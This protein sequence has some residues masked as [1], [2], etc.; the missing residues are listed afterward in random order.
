MAES[1]DSGTNKLDNIGASS[2]VPI[3]VPNSETIN[4]LCDHEGCRQLFRDKTLLQQHLIVH[5]KSKSAD[6][7]TNESDNLGVSSETPR[8]INS[9]INTFI[10]DYKG[11]L[12]LFKNKTL[13]KL[14]Q[15]D[16][17]ELTS[18]KCRYPGCPLIFS[19]MSHLQF[20]EKSHFGKQVKELKCN[21]CDKTFDKKSLLESHKLT[22]SSNHKFKC[23]LNG[24]MK[25]YS[26]EVELMHHWKVHADQRGSMELSDELETTETEKPFFCDEC[27]KSF[28][29]KFELE[30]HIHPASLNLHK[31][32]I[33]GCVKS[34]RNRKTLNQHKRYCLG[35]AVFECQHPGCYAI[36]SEEQ[37]LIR[38]KMTHDRP[39]QCDRSGC[40][41][42]F[43]D[44]KHLQQ[45]KLRCK[46]E[47]VGQEEGELSFKCQPKCEKAFAS[48]ELLELHKLGCEVVLEAIRQE[49]IEIKLK[50]PLAEPLRCSYKGCQEYFITNSN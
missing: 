45:H 21:H 6:S 50:T 43:P 34:F 10:C 20:H 16:H 18:Y 30:H 2:D 14:H 41:S 24:C 49:R 5:G 11:C 8:V 3:P 15:L 39:Y 23:G 9:G 35:K 37:L 48:Q 4:F 17:I 12:Q 1:L 31:C 13:L 36:F 25:A 32:D 44:Y 19:K 38:H 27:S 22:H 46:K 47:D 28:R 7:R 29:T 33:K 42:A 40:F 26:N